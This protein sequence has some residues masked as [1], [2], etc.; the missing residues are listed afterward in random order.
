MRKKPQVIQEI[1][2]VKEVDQL[3][4]SI[5]LNKI[6]LRN[7]EAAS[8][9]KIKEEK[10]KLAKAS[11]PI[12]AEIAKAEAS[13]EAFA[14]HNKAE[15]TKDKKTLVLNFGSI[16]FRESSS[17]SVKKT[18]LEKLEK[19][20]LNEA[21]KTTRSPNKDVLATYSDE[22]LAR[23]DAKREKKDTFWYEVKEDAALTNNNTDLK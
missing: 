9:I 10:K 14:L 1:N 19:L 6:K 22:K 20:M 2:T 11:E 21:I 18:T 3:L 8:D 5:A 16:G 4:L 17:I 15:L 7:K 23:V 12:Q 13:I